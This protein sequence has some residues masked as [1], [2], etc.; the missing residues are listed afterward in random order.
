MGG[1]FA[2]ASG[3]WTWRA[4]F[5][6][7]ALRPGCGQ[8]PQYERRVSRAVLGADLDF[9]QTVNLNVQLVATRHW[10]YQEPTQASGLLRTLELGRSRLNAE[11][12]AL[13]SGLTFRLSDRL[14]NDKLKWEIG[15]V[16]DLTGHSRLIRPRVSYAL[17]DYARLNAGIDFYAGDSQTY[18]G[19]LTK[20][21]LAFL[22]VS[23]VF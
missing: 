21:R 10:D 20:N 15:G 19:A 23:L 9:A 6:H 2:L 11:Y 12:A 17:S 7:A 13:E 16:F 22:M 14:L 3:A 18:F 8:C 1:D 4:E 5:S